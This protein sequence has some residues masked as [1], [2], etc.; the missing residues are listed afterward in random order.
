MKQLNNIFRLGALLLVSGLLIGHGATVPTRK[1]YAWVVHDSAKL[2]FDLSQQNPVRRFRVD[3]ASRNYLPH[4][5]IWEERLVVSDKPQSKILPARIRL[6]DSR[7]HVYYDVDNFRGESV[8]Y[9]TRKFAF[10]KL[11]PTASRVGEPLIASCV[12]QRC[13]ASRFIELRLKDPAATGTK[14]FSLSYTAL[15]RGPIYEENIWTRKPRM[16]GGVRI[17]VK[18]TA[19]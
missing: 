12:Q 8:D 3:L 9:R 11:S 10:A 7:G 16:P 6:L 5:P 1:V 17:T 19:Q 4:D 15:M 14:H 13:T 2:E 18:L